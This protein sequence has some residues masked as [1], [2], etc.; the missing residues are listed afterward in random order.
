[1]LCEMCA[2]YVHTLSLYSIIYRVSL[3]LPGPRAAL[4]SLC[5]SQL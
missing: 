4:L 3:S 1:M 2:V 5:V